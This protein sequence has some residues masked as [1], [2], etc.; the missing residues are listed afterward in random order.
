MDKS[1]KDVFDSE[2]YM[3]GTARQLVITWFSYLF[4]LTCT[5]MR[6]SVANPFVYCILI[7]CVICCKKKDTAEPSAPLVTTVGLTSITDSSVKAGGR[8]TSTG[9][10]E[11]TATGFCWSTLTTEPTIVD[12]TSLSA[13]TSSTFVLELNNL[14]PTTT[15]YIRAYAINSLGTGYGEVLSFNTINASPKIESVKANGHTIVD[16]ILTASYV[17]SDFENDP[18]SASVYQWYST[19]DPAGT[20]EP[21]TSANT[22]TYTVVITDTTRFIRVGVTPFSSAGTSPGKEV[23]SA[24]YGPVPVP[25][26]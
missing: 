6:V 1:R 10:E 22:S 12:D 8:I 18:D 17:Y 5:V 20:G 26:P 19:L 9:N 21:I 4:S 25:V 3:C 14:D 13:T 7:V 11:I 23:R 15:Y 24:W 16:S 2:H